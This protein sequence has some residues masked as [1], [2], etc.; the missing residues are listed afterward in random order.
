M[1]RN[2]GQC[3]DGGHL[4]PLQSLCFKQAHILSEHDKVKNLTVVVNI[5]VLFLSLLLSTDKIANF[6]RVVF[7]ESRKGRTIIAD[8]SFILVEYNRL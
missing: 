8:H 6:S 3:A 1:V 2:Y 4:R 7:R 5:D